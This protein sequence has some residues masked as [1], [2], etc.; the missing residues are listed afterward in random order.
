MS[1]YYIKVCINENCVCV[2][3]C[4]GKKKEQTPI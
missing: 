1:G 2:F 4:V 3:V